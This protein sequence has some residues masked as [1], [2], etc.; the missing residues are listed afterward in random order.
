MSVLVSEILSDFNIELSNYI[1]DPT[2]I[3]N[4]RKIRLIDKCQREFAKNGLAFDDIVF[5]NVVEDVD[6]YTLPDTFLTVY[7]AEY[8]GSRIIPLP[9]GI[10]NPSS[11]K[12][13]RI[14][15]HSIVLIDAPGE[16]GDEYL[17]VYF[18]RLPSITLSDLSDEVEL[19]N[20]HPEFQDAI[21]DYLLYEILKAKPETE[22]MAQHHWNKY[23]EAIELC[24]SK[25]PKKVMHSTIKMGV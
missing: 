12:F 17:K 8:N 20:K 1:P 22:K 7:P 19:A 21:V 5:I 13:Y 11:V 4:T 24:K 25:Q 9:Y 2:V 16:D 15:D 23:G 10:P 18:Y 14:Y 3:P 6:T